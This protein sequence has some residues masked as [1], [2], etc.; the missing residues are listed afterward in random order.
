MRRTA[1]IL[2]MSLLLQLLA[3]SAWAWRATQASGTSP[4][5]ATHCHVTAA[6]A[7]GDSNNHPA[8]KTA[9]AAWAQADSHHCCAVGLGSPVQPM[10]QPL[11]QTT[12]ASP[13]TPWASQNLQ[14]DLRPPI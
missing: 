1:W 14:P 10:L 6:E 5:H 4:A 3:G 9:A 12:P 7:A 13:H 8:P 2:L 11:P